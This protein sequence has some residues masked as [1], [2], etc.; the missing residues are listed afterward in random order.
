MHAKKSKKIISVII[1][2]AVIAGLA[3]GISA[4][5]KATTSSGR[6]AV[7]QASSADYVK[8]MYW[9]DSKTITGYV[10]SDASQNIYLSDAETVK[11][12]YVEEGDEV[13]EGDIIL[14]YDTTKTSLELQKRQ[15]DVEQIELTI[16]V[17][18]KN[19]QTLKN[20]T[21]I[22]DSVDD[23]DYIDDDYIDDGDYIDDDTD[24]GDDGIDDDDVDD[25]GDEKPEYDATVYDTL[26]GDSI[27]Y[28]A[29]DENVGS[30]ENPLKFLCKN[31][32]K[33]TADFVNMI[34]E[35]AKE[36]PLYFALEV[37]EEDSVSG[38]LMKA[39]TENASLLDEA[40]DDYEAYIKLAK[41]I[42]TPTPAPTEEPTPTA[43]P[44]PEPTIEP[45]PEPTI[46]P[47]SDPQSSPTDGVT[48]SATTFMIQKVYKDK[49]GS[50]YVAQ[51][52]SLSDSVSQTGTALS[53]E[54]AND[55]SSGNFDLS[56]S[57]L[58]SPNAEYTKENLAQALKD[59]E[60]KL[61]DA[62]LDLREAQLNLNLAQKA[63]DEGTVKAKIDGVVKSVGDL[64]NPNTGEA[65]ITINAAK[66]LYL[67]CGLPEML[68]GSLKD[69]D[70][71]SVQSWDTGN[72]YDAVVK[73]ISDMPDTSG[74]YTNYNFGTDTTY[75]PFTA[76]I[77]GGDDLQNN[78]YVQITLNGMSGG[79][80]YESDDLYLWKAFILEKD[81]H[82]YVYKRG[83]NDKLVKTEITVGELK[84]QGYLILD[85]VT[86]DDWIAFPY[87]SGVKDGANTRETTI[88]EL[89]S[90]TS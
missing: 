88:D 70:H 11:Q 10:S 71:V 23:G 18:E 50:S 28:N 73:D 8:T 65:F 90:E 5:V 72:T 27:A 22:S 14:S 74:D 42:V 47:T 6:I 64:N 37:R 57:E 66:G 67:R 19:V 45:T 35:L 69:G 33:I 82:K 58:I 62:K 7:I 84:G 55:S 63:A 68:Y 39:W 80:D 53:N 36:E 31:G 40:D 29:D 25:G 32:T 15:L 78:Y 46:E 54:D 51:F 79:I 30:E 1:I 43:E 89:Y 61:R 21:P 48:G 17:A 75:Y 34:R 2:I 56:T 9:E 41:K 81:G 86:N 16:K 3:V 59:E 76:E 13:K 38:A 77:D 83:D 52:A 85:G 26:D 44:T 87:G 49:T 24:N 60:E 20:L 12:V 4:A